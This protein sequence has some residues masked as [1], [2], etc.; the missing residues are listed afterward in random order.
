MTAERPG[1]VPLGRPGR[2]RML[3]SWGVC[4]V[5]VFAAIFLLLLSSAG[6]GARAKDDFSLVRPLV[7][8]EQLLW[9][10]GK[11]IGSVDT[12]RIPLITT[13]PRGTLLAFAEARKM[14]ASDKGAKFI[15]LRRSTDQGS[16]W[17]PTAFIVDDGESPDGLNLGAVVS[18]TT[19]GVVFLFYSLCAHKAGC[20][21]A[22]TMLVW[23]KDD[24]ISWSSPRNLSLDIGT[25]MFAPGPGSGIQKQREPR[26]GR[27][28]V[29]GH[30]TLE[31]DGVFC[32]LSDDRGASWHYGSGV[33]G[34]P[35]GQPKRENDFSPDECQPF[36]LPDGSVVINARNQNNYH[37][38]C[39]I[40]LRSY[41]ACDTLRPRDVTFDPELVDPVVAAGAVATNSGIVFFSNPAHPEF[42]F[43]HKPNYIQKLCWRLLHHT[44]ER[45][46]PM[47]D[48]TRVQEQQGC[49][50]RPNFGVKLTS[51]RTLPKM[52]VQLFA[53][54]DSTAEACGGYVHTYYG[55]VPP[56]FLTPK[57]PSCSCVDREV[58]LDLRSGHLIS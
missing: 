40:I 20:Q 39:R 41:D 51:P 10:S 45:S 29:C 25:E 54:M 32:L 12:F 14:S 5:Q 4:R 52:G 37:C 47:V 6:V 43:P 33:S 48:P 50:M 9:V 24:G 22:S 8:M 38:R 44:E 17:S 21:V 15:A 31:R 7:T 49:E 56:P 27:L 1:T 11:Q 53:K 26:K 36:E 18:D 57:E 34:I 13:T 28:I 46:E 3:G 55:V 30:G 58:Y 19:T 35:Y 2:P 16:T 42:R 23:S